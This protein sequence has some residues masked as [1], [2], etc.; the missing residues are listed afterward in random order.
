M[1]DSQNVVHLRLEGLKIPNSA[2]PSG[3]TEVAGHLPVA[4]ISVSQ[5]AI[6][7]IGE[8]EAIDLEGYAT[9]KAEWE[10]GRAGIFTISLAEIA[11]FLEEAMKGA[12]QS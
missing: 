2:A 8:G 12:P 1:P 9:W 10:K 3:F 4:E 5:S 6:H 7:K 11:D